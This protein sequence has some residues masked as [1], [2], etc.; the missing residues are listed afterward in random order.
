MTPNTLRTFIAIELESPIQ[1]TLKKIQDHLRKSGAEVKWVNLENIH[2]T[3]KFLGDV[4]EEK[5]DSLVK[6]LKEVLLDRPDFTFDLTHLGAFP[7]PENPKIIWAGITV[8]KEEI[9][10]IVSILEDRLHSIG[11]EKETR[12]F[13]PHVTLGRLHSS[14]NRFAL[15]E[16]I[17]NYFFPQAMNQNAKQII[18]FKSTLT[19]SGPVYEPLEK[20]ALK[21]IEK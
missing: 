16:L 13:A 7:K 18:L 14:I 6:N 12:D 15:S 11:F 20:F 1:E 10:K 4:S 3:L 2:L 9:A 21:A 19:S 17:K 5:I 8:G